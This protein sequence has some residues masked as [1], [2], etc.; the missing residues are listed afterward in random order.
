M[1]N[2]KSGAIHFLS[3][4]PSAKINILVFL[5]FF[6]SFLDGPLIV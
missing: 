6:F 3:S 2:S 5:F 1:R 4:M